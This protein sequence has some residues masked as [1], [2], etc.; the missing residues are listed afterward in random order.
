[1]VNTAQDQRFLLDN[2]NIDTSTI[3][4]YVKGINDTGLGREFKMVDNILNIDNTSEIF[5]IQEVQEE[6][7]ELLFG[8]GY[9]GKKL[10]NNAVV[11]VSYIV[12]DGEAGNGPSLFDFQGNFV[13]EGGIRVIPS[14]S[15]PVV[16]VQK[17]QNGGC[18]LYTSP[19]PRDATLSRMPSSA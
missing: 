17:A 9:F 8:D 3:R 11:T 4:V 7:Y 19:S 14:A 6:R 1:M 2:P 12:T 13:D 10:E 18:L 16:T 5:L 15:V